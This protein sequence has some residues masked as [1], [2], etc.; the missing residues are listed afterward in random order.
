MLRLL[1]RQTVK[2]MHRP[3][4]R[5]STMNYVH[6]LQTPYSG[7]PSYDTIAQRF[8]S[9]HVDPQSYFSRKRQ[10][11]AKDRGEFSDIHD[12]H[13]EYSPDPNEYDVVLSDVT[14]EKLKSSIAEELGITYLSKAVDVEG[15]VRVGTGYIYGLHKRTIVP[16]VVSHGEESRWVFFIVDSGSPWTYISIQV[17]LYMTSLLRKEPNW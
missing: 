9:S 8:S 5:L 4:Y 13:P 3:S 14:H 7:P 11:E 2:A 16:F 15:P 12:V 17:W 10:Q 6:S 1:T